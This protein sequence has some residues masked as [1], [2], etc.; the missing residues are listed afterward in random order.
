MSKLAGEV[1]LSVEMILSGF[2]FLFIIITNIASGRFGYETFSDLDF[3]K[4]LAEI[5]KDP[6]KFK[7]GTALIL[8]EHIGIISV[9][10]MLFLAFYSYSLFLAVVWTIFRVT[11]A[12]IQIYNKSSYWRLLS[13]AKQYSNPI[14]AEKTSLS[15]VALDIIKTKN[16]VFTFAQILFSIG[17][18]TYSILFVTYGVV[19]E[20]MGWFGI[21]ASVLYGCGSGM[22]LVKPNFKVLWSLGGLLILIFELVL[23]GWLLFYPLVVP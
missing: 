21:V 8:I 2:F 23:G 12:L 17:T 10:L 11:E 4:K 16:F 15:A 18:L 9:A 20:I 7:I 5:N 6:R 3:N 1:S 19:P 22:V 14:G 13:I